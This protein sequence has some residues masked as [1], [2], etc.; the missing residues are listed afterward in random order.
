MSLHVYTELQNQKSLKL[1]GE[2]RSCLFVSLLIVSLHV[3]LSRVCRLLFSY[4]FSSRKGGMGARVEGR[5][6]QFKNFLIGVER[7]WL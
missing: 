7:G 6:L 2:R 4:L 5:R 1:S 3:C